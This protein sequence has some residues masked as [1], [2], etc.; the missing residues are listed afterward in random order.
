MKKNNNDFNEKMVK[1]HFDQWEN[2]CNKNY[3]V[4]VF[5]I[6]LNLNLGSLSIFADKCYSK[7]QIATAM[8][9]IL[10]FWE[11]EGL[12]KAESLIIPT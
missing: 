10:S 7:D 6:G 9:E 1:P 3:S 5:M 12:N 4:P 2:L 11:K 8:R